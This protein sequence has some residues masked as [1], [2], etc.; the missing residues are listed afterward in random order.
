MAWWIKFWANVPDTPLAA[1]YQWGPYETELDARI[2]ARLVQA[3]RVE[4]IEEDAGED[5]WSFPAY[6]PGSGRND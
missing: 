6:P 1:P 3:E 5:D 2:D 4:V